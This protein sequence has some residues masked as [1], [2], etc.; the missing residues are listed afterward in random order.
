[1]DDPADPVLLRA[2]ATLMLVRDV[3]PSDGP[4]IEVLLLRRSADAVFLP[5]AYVFPGGAV[6]PADERPATAVLSQDLDDIGASRLLGL[7]TG[8]LAFWVA[9]LREC[10]EE[11]GILLARPRG[12]GRPPAAGRLAELRRSLDSGRLDFTELCGRDDLV[13]ATDAV[14]YV[15]H[16]ITPEGSVRR[17]DT[18][19]F[20]A[21]APAGQVAAHDNRET[22]ATLWI[23]P[24]DALARGR[25][26]EIRLAT[27]T[28]ANLTDLARYRSVAE[29]LS[30]AQKL[31]EQGGH[32][33]GP[34]PL[35]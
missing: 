27:P 12:A 17:Y 6:D 8:G 26:G 11:T 2:A 18:R 21:E 13:L 9:A 28:V 29:V 10:F 33:V 24:S 30:W 34:V 22:V 31:K 5:G 16:W 19:F 14:E 4:G 23:Q 35:G 3:A 25:S 15:S 32:G 20:V 1:M 7:P